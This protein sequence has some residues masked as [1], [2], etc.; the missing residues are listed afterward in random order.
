MIYTEFDINITATGQQSDAD[1]ARLN[2]KN[3]T[4]NSGSAY[5]QLQEETTS[6]EVPE[7]KVNISTLK[8]VLCHQPFTTTNELVSVH[9]VIQNKHRYWIHRNCAYYSPLCRHAARDGEDFWYN[10]VKEIQC[11]RGIKCA[12]CG[13]K[14]ATIGCSNERCSKSYHYRCAQSSGHDFGVGGFNCPKHR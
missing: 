9:P 10:V 11:G 1:G 6:W 3:L 12:V 8:C 2:V 4:N 14:G 13:E 7:M 5:I